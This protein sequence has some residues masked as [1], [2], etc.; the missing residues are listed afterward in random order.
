MSLADEE[1]KLSTV[2]IDHSKLNKQKQTFDDLGY[3]VI[4]NALP[5]E[6]V[7]E[8]LQVIEELRES[9]ENDPKRSKVEGGLNIRPII[10]KHPAFMDLL[11]CPNTFA[12][13]TK[14]LGHYNIQLQ[15][16]NLIEAH[17]S[18]ERRLTGWHSDGGMPSIGVNGIRAFGSLK[19]AYFLRDLTEP[20]M[21]QLMLAPGS[22]RVQGAPPFLP[23]E[24]NPAGA[25]QIQANA[26][27]A[28]IFQ[29]GIW[30]AAAPNY[31]TQS[32]IALY[33]GYSYRVLRPVD[34]QTMPEALLA[35]CT[36]VEKQ[37]LG[38]TVN[39]QGYYVPTQEDTPLQ[40]WFFDHFDDDID[41]GDLE[42]V[43]DVS[44][45]GSS[46]AP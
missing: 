35:D 44:L 10:E 42:R 1:P 21:G 3:V 46:P 30:H 41:R 26:G 34:Y 15:Q 39:H 38:E 27:D 45:T 14:L 28:V 36:P 31:S 37:L 9:L 12:A 4:R 5:Q 18:V 17:P 22:H 32:R 19:V 24:S 33:Y 23:D 29:Q 20:D 11:I 43:G 7:N 40:T 16:S 8:L 2:T 25:I 6:Q 13:V